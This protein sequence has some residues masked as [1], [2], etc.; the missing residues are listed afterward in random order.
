MGSSPRRRGGA[1][2]LRDVSRETTL[3][4]LLESARICFDE[5]G[6]AATIE[7][8][9]D[10]ANASRGTF[11]LHFKGKTDVVA[12]LYRLDYAE[13][14]D[15]WLSDLPESAELDRLVDWL[16]GYFSLYLRNQKVI[17]LWKKSG[18]SQDGYSAEAQSAIIEF[19]NSL[20][21][22]VYQQRSARGAETT[23]EDAYV[24]GAHA[25]TLTHQ[26]TYFRVTQG[27]GPLTIDSHMHMVSLAETWQ[28]TLGRV[29]SSLESV[30]SQFHTAS[31]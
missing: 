18:Y 10:H 21:A 28:A 20:G 29:P 15:G 1:R 30:A 14:L 19:L 24:R 9:C 4:R 6:D 17:G 2:T 13:K 12:L 7:E 26:T 8:I 11:Y 3:A 27:F 23:A 25:Y 5:R 16:K 22:V 31:E